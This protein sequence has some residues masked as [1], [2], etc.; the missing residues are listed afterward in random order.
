GIARREQLR[1]GQY[2]ARRVARCRKHRHQGRVVA[3]GPSNRPGRVGA[4]SAGL[5]EGIEHKIVAAG[6]YRI[7]EQ[8]AV[9]ITEREAAR[10]GTA[11]RDDRSV[12]APYRAT[13][14][15][16]IYTLSLLDALPILGIARR[17]QLRAGQYRARRVA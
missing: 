1:A 13:R 5:V 9:G 4:D 8:P 11:R 12:V 17:E 14:R 7:G 15:I 2:R 3:A 16:E 6:A 10:C